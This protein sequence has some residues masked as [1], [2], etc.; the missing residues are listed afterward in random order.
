MKPEM[1]WFKHAFA[2]IVCA[3]KDCQCLN[4]GQ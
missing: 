4:Y 3:K 2:L 1:L